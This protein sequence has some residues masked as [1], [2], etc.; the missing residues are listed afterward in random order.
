MKTL[1][2]GLLAAPLLAHGAGGHHSVDDAAILPEGACQQE[3]WASGAQAGSRLVHVGGACRLGPVQLGIA[4]EYAR[5]PDASDTA[6]GL[7][8]KWARDVTP[9]VSLGMVAQPVWQAHLR[10]RYQGVSAQALATWRPRDTVAIH[11]NAGRDF[12]N[13]G[14]GEKRGGVAAEW[15]PVQDWWLTVERYREDATHFTRAGVRW[16]ASQHWSVDIS[17]AQRLAGPGASNWTIGLS[18]CFGGE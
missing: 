18:F 5:D 4:A 14:E 15:M 11:A 2:S 8:V 12:L 7:Q 10:P 1:L 9:T 6:W 13:G 16:L 3:N 17:R